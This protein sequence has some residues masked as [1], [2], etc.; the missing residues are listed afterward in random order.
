M[1]F[2]V[3]DAPRAVMDERVRLRYASPQRKSA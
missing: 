2:N 3:G 1:M